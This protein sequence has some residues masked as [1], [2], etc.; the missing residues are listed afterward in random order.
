MGKRYQECSWLEK[1]Y[2]WIRYKP[3][4][5]IKAVLIFIRSKNRRKYKFKS[6]WRI[7]MS[8]AEMKMNHY[9]TM[10][11]VQEHMRKIMETHIDE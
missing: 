6:I 4:Y 3:L 2:R 10:N 7:H 5:V 9:Y 11:E 1:S 8:L